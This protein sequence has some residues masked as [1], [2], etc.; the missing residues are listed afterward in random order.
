MSSG[1]ST[2]V[3]LMN[4]A[5]TRD[6]EAAILLQAAAIAAAIG[7]TQAGVAGA[8]GSPFATEQDGGSY[9][10]MALRVGGEGLQTIAHLKD[11]AAGLAGIL[12][13]YQRRSDEWQF[14]GDV[15]EQDRN[16]LDQQI[17]AAQ[18]RIAVAQNELAN[19]DLQM[20]QARAVEDQL[21]SKY[22][23][24]Q[25]YTWMVGQLS[26]IYFQ[27]YQ[28]A[29][30]VAKEAERAWQFEL[31]PLTPTTFIQFGY[32]DS[33]KKGLLAG[34][35]L[36]YDLRR[37]EVAYLD[38]N[39]REYELTSHVSLRVL[40]PIALEA[41]RTTGECVV[42]VPEYWYDL[43]SP[44]HYLRRLK[45]VAISLP[46]VT[47]P[48]VP[49]RCT[50][51]LASS[52]IRTSTKTDAGYA[53]TGTGDSRFQYNVSGPQSVVTSRA[54]EDTGLFET[55]LRDERYLP[56][57][58][59]GA[60]SN[61]QIQ[62]PQQFRQFD[63]ATITD[64]VLHIRYTA[65]DGGAQFATAAQ[66]SL[67][68]L[69][70]DLAQ[71]ISLREEMP[72]LLYQ[73][74][75]PAPDATGQQI[76]LPL[77]K[78]RFPYFVQGNTITITAVDLLMPVTDLTGYKPVRFQITP[79]AGTAQAIDLESDTRYYGGVPHNPE[80]LG[81]TGVVGAWTLAFVE[82]DNASALSAV[83]ITTNGHTRLDPAAVRDLVLVVHYQAT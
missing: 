9:V 72:D 76:T 5:A 56:F 66:T 11:R 80:T 74:L 46:C 19:L 45:S 20:S 16:S 1:E 57:E 38:Q 53:S 51:T 12:A 49:V 35:R 61:W 68:P 34:E 83:V 23:N 50:L 14:Q 81:I 29:Y 62:L 6:G 10:A 8:G 4:L 54:Q 7:D 18:I 40:D 22:T 31:A 64:A 82:A 70:D 47:G 37:M 63:Y 75:H 21:H 77:D 42:S 30:A 65:R 24:Q 41:L 78:S 27:G 17:L 58:G 15:A 13:S 59:Q 67:L 52:S 69:L 79:P 43:D 2:E 36:G 25:L 28:L 71:A 26:S 3:G 55:N 44:G 33:L 39:R 48:Y 73:L 32:W 60:V